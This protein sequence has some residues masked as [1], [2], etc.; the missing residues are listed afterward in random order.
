MRASVS[1]SGGANEHPTPLSRKKLLFS[2]GQEFSDND[3]EASLSELHMHQVPEEADAIS[4]S[5]D[6]E[7][8]RSV[9]SSHRNLGK[10]CDKITVA[11]NIHHGGRR[12]GKR[13][14]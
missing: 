9:V 11:N 2:S 8:L 6:E 4:P 5:S 7:F 14:T 12:Q 1:Q 13:Q 3:R 10:T